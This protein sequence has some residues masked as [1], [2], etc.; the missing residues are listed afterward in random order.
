MLSAECLISFVPYYSV[1]ISDPESDVPFTKLLYSN[2]AVM[3]A[4]YDSLSEDGILVMQL[5]ESP[6]PRNAAETHSK[7]KN[8]DATTELL[9]RVGFQS[10][11]AY[12][13]VSRYG[14]VFTCTV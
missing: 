14:F 8:R 11:H 5:G 4:F 9:E 10:I 2:D 13:E 6:T 7:A 12:E 3:R 1:P